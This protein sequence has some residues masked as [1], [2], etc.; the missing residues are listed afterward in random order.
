MT[1]TRKTRKPA[2]PTHTLTRFTDPHLRCAQCGQRTPAWH[3]DDTCGTYHQP[4]PAGWYLVPCGHQAAAR[5]GKA[6]RR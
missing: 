4:C 5:Q 3:D 1:T 6:A 2:E